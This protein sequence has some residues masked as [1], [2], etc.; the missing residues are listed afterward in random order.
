MPI[1]AA[2]MREILMP[3]FLPKQQARLQNFVSLLTLNDNLSLES[4]NWFPKI[5][6]N[7]ESCFLGNAF[8]ITWSVLSMSIAKHYIIYIITFFFFFH[9]STLLW[10]TRHSEKTLS[11][12]ESIIRSEGNKSLSLSSY[13]IMSKISFYLS[14]IVWSFPKDFLFKLQ[15]YVLLQWNSLH[16]GYMRLIDD[17]CFSH[18]TSHLFS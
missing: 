7:R 15:P 8:S 5:E 16:I 1:L 6:D 11:N 2:K 12:V 14:N 10:L 4:D 3:A 18:F 9:Q 13:W 17:I